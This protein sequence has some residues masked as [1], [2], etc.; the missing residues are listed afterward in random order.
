MPNAS[1]IEAKTADDLLTALSGIA[2][3]RRYTALM[4][5]NVKILRAA[6]DLCGVDSVDMTKRAAALAIVENF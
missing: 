3:D 4:I 6:A 2:R 5:R 1:I